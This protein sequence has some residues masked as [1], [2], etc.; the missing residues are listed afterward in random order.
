[1]TRKQL[2]DTEFDALIVRSLSRLPS[3]APSRVFSDR[4]MDRVQLPSP[5]PVVAWRRARSWVAQPR[6][7]VALAGV[8]AGM[9]TIAL[10]VAV[11][12]LLRNS[13]AIRFGFDWTMARGGAV[14]RDIAIAVAGWTVSSG[15]TGVIKSIPL[16]GPQVWALAFGATAAYAGCAIGLHYLLRAPKDKHEPVQIQA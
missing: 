14:M 7:A 9:A 11:P 5:R 6:R 12:W 13:P 2:T 3:H 4:V 1:M 16:S 15:I 8:Y 10:L